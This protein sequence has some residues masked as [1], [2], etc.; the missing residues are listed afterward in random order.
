MRAWMGMRMKREEAGGEVNR[1]E[2]N[3]RETVEGRH[4]ARWQVPRALAPRG[5]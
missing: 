1:G 3:N 5:V 4:R 2:M